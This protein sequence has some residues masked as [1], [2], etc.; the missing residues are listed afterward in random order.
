MLLPFQAF[1]HGLWYRQH[2]G[3]ESLRDAAVQCR[4]LFSY[5]ATFFFA[6]TLSSFTLF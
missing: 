5:L 3:R 1:S 6:L 2:H 4:A